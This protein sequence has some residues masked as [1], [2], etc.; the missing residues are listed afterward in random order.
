MD[1]ILGAFGEAIGAF[2]EDPTIQLAMRAIGI[3]VVLIWLAAAYWAYRDLQTR[4]ANPIAPYLAAA[5]I[6][7]FTPLLFP[8]WVLLYRILRPGETVAEANERALA[9]EAMLVEVESQPHCANCARRVHGDWIIC[10]TCRNRL[11]R[12]CPNCSRLVELDW[13]LCAWCGKDFE[14][15]ELLRDIPASATAPAL[16]ASRQALGAPALEQRTADE[17]VTAG[18]PQLRLEA[19]ERRQQRP[20]IGSGPQEPLA[21]GSPPGRAASRPW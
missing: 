16:A 13:T 14:R 8:F 15:Q 5:L 1:Q 2:F 7:L 9:E 20:A 6:I 17:T 18:R 11:R 12:V 21:E 19:E 10:P 4:T 3:Y